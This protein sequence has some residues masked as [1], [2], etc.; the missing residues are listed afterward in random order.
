MADRRHDGAMGNGDTPADGHRDLAQAVIDNA[1]FGAH[2]YR[3][4][5]DDR[6]VFIGFN[7]K[8]V[9][10]LDLDHRPLLGKTLE[11]AFP[12]TVGTDAPE[13]YRR[14]ARDGG[15]YDVDQFAYDAER[16]TGVFEVHAFN[17]GQRQ[18]SVF[19]RDVTETRLAEHRMLELSEMLTIA[20]RAARA[21]FWSWDVPSGKLTWT[22]EFFALF[23][24]PADAEPS[25]PTWRAA[26]HPDDVEA[27][28]ARI[29][30]ALEEHAPL[31]NEYRV[32]LADGTERWIGAVGTT[33]YADD[34]SPL[35]MSGICLDIDERKHREEEIRALNEELEGRVAERTRELSASIRELEQFVY[36]VSHD[37]R[38]PL[39]ALDGFSQVLL[40]DYDAALDDEGRD[41]LRR[42]RH[43]A[44]HMAELIDALLALAKVGRRQVDLRMVDL[45]AAAERILDEL[46][47]SDPGR[48]VSVKVEDGLQAR[49]DEALAD[50]VLR[51]LLGN[52]WKFTALHEAATIAVGSVRRGGRV[53]FYVRDNGA[54]FDQEYAATMFDPFRR[55]HEHAEYPGTGIGLA[56][57]RR[58][59][60]KLGG[61]CWAEG[62]PGEGA[63]FFF[64]LG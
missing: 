29:M 30:S 34:G 35:R 36:S 41:H 60:E 26:L 17:F 20:Q 11:E 1:P 64:T 50:I 52:A 21:G 38:S 51:N 19:F 15:T 6:L 46:R 7:R 59:L 42:I 4:D 53:A 45:T 56:T 63:T 33:S 3:L 44:Q 54:G 55:L 13:A 24:L 5:P 2:M 58:A 32:V 61:D 25:F 57:V 22:P 27:A 47:H 39:R 28:E 43:A 37:L 49:T 12:G 10:M 62:A 31:E 40:E 8:A 14:V 16:I 48:S 9:E 23:G 18:V